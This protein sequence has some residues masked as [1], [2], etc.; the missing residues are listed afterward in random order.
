[1]DTSARNPEA[2]HLDAPFLKQLEATACDLVR[3]MSDFTR[4]EYG[5]TRTVSYKDRAEADPV[6]AVDR[7]VEAYLAREVAARFPEH[8]VLGEEGSEPRAGADWVWIVDP[9]DGTRNFVAGLP[10]YA[11]SVGVLYRG[12][13]VV[14]V[15]AL[16]HSGSLV[17][18]HLGGGAFEN[19]QPI[20]VSVETTL[21]PRQLAVQSRDFWRE[22]EVGAQAVG[23]LGDPRWLGSTALELAMIAGGVID[24]GMFASSA[25][26]DV[27]AG[28]LLVL[29]AGGAV[30]RF[31]E[32]QRNWQVLTDFG[33]SGDAALRRWDEPLLVGSRGLVSE[34]AP[35]VRP[36]I[37]TGKG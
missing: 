21:H 27:A 34:L 8:T 2:G 37:G 20:R 3:E 11:L 9:V 5:R 4:S 13:P 15:V 7:A 14:G 30:L 12:R 18:A 36:V 1:M 23:R 16:T 25:L 29:E 31:S 26:W 17:H 32:Q 10:L 33:G 6:T 22:W 19:G 24:Y 28:V 35:L